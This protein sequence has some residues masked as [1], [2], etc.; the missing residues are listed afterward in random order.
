MWEINSEL[1]ATLDYQWTGSQNAASRHTGETVVEK[2]DSYDELDFNIAWK[3]AERITL[4]F[5]LDNALDQ[6]YFNAVG[7]PG[8]GRSGRVSISLHN[9]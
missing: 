1:R 6:H 5:A 7:F 4:A 3:M 8:P 9:D 2:L